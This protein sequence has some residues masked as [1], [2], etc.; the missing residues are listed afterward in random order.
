MRTAALVA[1]FHKKL[2]MSPQCCGKNKHKAKVQ[3]ARCVK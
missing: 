1:I 2:S 3:L